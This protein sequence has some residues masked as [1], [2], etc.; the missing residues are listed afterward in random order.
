MNKLIIAFDANSIIN[1]LK[2][3]YFFLI[4][5]VKKKLSLKE[6]FWKKTK[7][8]ANHATHYSFKLTRNDERNRRDVNKQLEYIWYVFKKFR[9][10]QDEIKHKNERDK[11]TLWVKREKSVE[12][13]IMNDNDKVF[14]YDE[15]RN[16]LQVRERD[17]ENK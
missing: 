8:F 11:K 10:N 2:E 12:N 6:I 3:N 13:D 5:N 9:I 14:W 4:I 1:S 17:E 16:A 7:G 15:K